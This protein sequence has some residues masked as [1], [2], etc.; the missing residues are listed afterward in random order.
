MSEQAGPHRIEVG[1]ANGPDGRPR[2]LLQLEDGW[3]L[4]SG[5]DAYAIANA[6]EAAAD[7]LAP[8]T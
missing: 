5:A 8:P 4:M 2:V 1:I 6:L 3:T 7:E